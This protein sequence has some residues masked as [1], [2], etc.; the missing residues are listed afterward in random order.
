MTVDDNGV[1][2]NDD[3]V[4][5]GDYNYDEDSCDVGV[6]DDNFNGNDDDNSRIAQHVAYLGRGAVVERGEAGGD[7]R[8]IGCAVQLQLATAYVTVRVAQTNWNNNNAE[9][10]Q[11]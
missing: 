8:L 3:D 9:G 1:A 10:L 6:S 2:G 5:A 11:T 4:D 7:P